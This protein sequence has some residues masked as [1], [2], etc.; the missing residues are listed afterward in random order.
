MVANF[1]AL[2]AVMFLTNEP[3]L[4]PTVIDHIVDIMTEKAS[5]NGCGPEGLSVLKSMAEYTNGIAV[6][7]MI[8][9]RTSV[10]GL[11]HLIS[12]LQPELMFQSST[13]PLTPRQWL[14]GLLFPQA[15]VHGGPFG[16]GV[17]LPCTGCSGD[18]VDFGSTSAGSSGMSGPLM[19]IRLKDR[20]SVS[21]F[22]TRR[23]ANSEHTR[24]LGRSTY[25]DCLVCLIYLYYSPEYVIIFLY[26][27][28]LVHVTDKA[29]RGKSVMVLGDQGYRAAWNR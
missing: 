26:F 23:A 10:S 20:L 14:R 13:S 6:S 8:G 16:T 2:L 28:T 15:A 18:H 7:A 22:A 11:R 27:A 21:V 5:R 4:Y 19:S 17:P 29:G 24:A 1:A 3:Y 9:S 25:Y 12:R